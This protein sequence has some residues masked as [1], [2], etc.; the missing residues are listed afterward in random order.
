MESVVLAHGSGADEIGMLVMVV[1][2]IIVA[3]VLAERS[4][5]QNQ[6]ARGPVVQPPAASTRR[7]ED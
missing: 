1:V 3:F 4:S 7:D 6:R 5:R 2:G